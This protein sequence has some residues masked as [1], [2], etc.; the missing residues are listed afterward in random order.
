MIDA[1]EIRQLI[2]KLK[3]QGDIS[4]NEADEIY[5]QENTKSFELKKVMEKWYEVVAEKIRKNLRGNFVFTIDLH[6]DLE[7]MEPAQDAIRKYGNFEDLWDFIQVDK[8]LYSLV[9]F[10]HLFVEAGESPLF[11]NVEIYYEMKNSR[12]GIYYYPFKTATGT[13]TISHFMKRFYSIP[14]FSGINAGV[15]SKKF[16]EIAAGIYDIPLDFYSFKNVREIRHCILA[17]FMK[18]KNIPCIVV[19]ALYDNKSI[20][21]I[22]EENA[23]AVKRAM[24]TSLEKLIENA[25]EKNIINKNMAEKFIMRRGQLENFPDEE[26]AEACMKY[27]DDR[28]KMK[29]KW[30]ATQEEVEESNEWLKEV[31]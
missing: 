27:I 7:F 1:D 16:F 18:R 9:P 4:V 23:I 17:E 10:K 15:T 11:K 21:F 6:K 24:E 30:K 8:R 5:S 13:C 14:A 19:T 28:V 31:R 12:A 22:E 29:L 26:F 2:Q 20:L 3:D 25:I